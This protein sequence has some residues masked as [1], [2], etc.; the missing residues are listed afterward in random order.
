MLNCWVTLDERDP[1]LVQD[2]HD[3]GEIEE[4]PGQ[5]V[6]LVDNDA[7]DA[8]RLDVGH[9]P[10]QRGPVHV[11]AREPTVVVGVGQADPAFKL[12]G[13]DVR[14]SRLPLGIEGVELL[15]E[16]LLCGF[17]GVHGAA[18]RG[19]LGVSAADHRVAPFASPKNN[20]PF[21]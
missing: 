9:Q 8:P 15:V 4:R 16:P 11:P 19:G 20:I 10:P 17:A 12:L 7:V 3:P 21:Q 13:C 6:D 18:G 1:V 14:F 5:P 2:L